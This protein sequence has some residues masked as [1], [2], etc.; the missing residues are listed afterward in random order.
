M[1]FFMGGNGVPPVFFGRGGGESDVHSRD[2]LAVF[3][4]HQNV[5]VFV[6]PPVRRFEPKTHDDFDVGVCLDNRFES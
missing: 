5:G 1:N 3:G 4:A 6:E 2:E